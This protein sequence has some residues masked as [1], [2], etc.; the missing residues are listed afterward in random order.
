[1]K[2]IE[3]PKNDRIKQIKKLHTKKGRDESRLFLIE[4]VHLIEEALKYDGII[5]EIYVEE[6]FSLPPHFK[7]QNV[8]VT[9][10]TERVMIEIAQ[11]ETPQGIVAVCKQLT[12][13]IN[14]KE[15]SYLLID[16]VQDPGNVGT[17]I[18]TAD[19][20]GLTAVILGKGTVDVYND[21]VIRASQGSIFHIPVLK[22][23][24]C[25]WIENN[26]EN[27]RIYGTALTNGKSYETVEKRDN[28]ALIV[29]NEGEGV[30]EELLRKTDANLF[31]PI[32]GK[33]ESL[34]VAVATGILL[35]Q[36][37]K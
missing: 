31:I 9:Y 14:F 16:R 35:Y 18:R 36:L 5:K 15:G 26:G 21:K 2:R 29:G 32:Y 37:K 34:N 1:M 19:A 24:L 30:S 33:A 12:H 20:A 7:L 23:N 10:V 22:E 27:I 3:S 28:F 6:N 8:A 25:D 13:R 17:M 11:T 4:G